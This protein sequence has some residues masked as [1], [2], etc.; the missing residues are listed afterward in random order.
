[1]EKGKL[2]GLTT[3]NLFLVSGVVNRSEYMGS[4]SSS[5]ITRAVCA[6]DAVEAEKKLRKHFELQS[7]PYGTYYSTHGVSVENVIV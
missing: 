2:F 4:T 1:M 7:S 3:W 6:N 5:Q